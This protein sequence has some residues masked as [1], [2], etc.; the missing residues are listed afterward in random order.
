MIV[1]GRGAKIMGKDTSEMYHEEA[2]IPDLDSMPRT[3]IAFARS[4]GELKL[5]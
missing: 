4:D 1:R 5:I 3:F 2:L